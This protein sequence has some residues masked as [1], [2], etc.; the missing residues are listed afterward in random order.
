MSKRTTVT[1]H[2]VWLESPYGSTFVDSIET[3]NIDGIQQ[4]M[5]ITPCYWF[6]MAQ[7]SGRM[8]SERIAD[9]MECEK[10]HM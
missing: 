6:V 9:L 3:T 10:C 5:K 1:V 4:S 8:I 7:Q 2:D